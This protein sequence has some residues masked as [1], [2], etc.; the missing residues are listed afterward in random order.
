MTIIIAFFLFP[1]LFKISPLKCKLGLFKENFLIGL[2]HPCDYNLVIANKTK[3]ISVQFEGGLLS[4][5]Q[6]DG[7]SLPF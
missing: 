7:L 2:Y 6:W 4:T 3:I 5:G 1:C